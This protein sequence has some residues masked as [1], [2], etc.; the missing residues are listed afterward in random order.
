MLN[1][2]DTAKW[3]SLKPY[4]QNE[5]VTRGGFIW[6]SKGNG[7]QGHDPLT[8][9]S[10]TYW[11]KFSGSGGGS[12]G[13]NYILNPTA[14]S[15]DTSSWN[16]Y[17]DQVS[18][19]ISTSFTAATNLV[20]R[21][22]HGFVVGDAVVFISGTLGGSLVT[23]TKYYVVEVP[24]SGSFKLSLTR[25][26]AIFDITSDQGANTVVMHRINFVNGTSGTTSADLAFS[27]SSSTPERGTFS[28]LLSK[29]SVSGQAGKGVSTDFT[30]D[31]ADRGNM[32]QISFDLSL[33][34]SSTFSEGDIEIWIYDVTNASLIQPTPFKVAGMTTGATNHYRFVSFFQANSTSTSYRFG[35]HWMNPISTLYSVKMDS[36]LVA[37]QTQSVGLAAMDP[38]EYFPDLTSWTA[39]ALTNIS[40]GRLGKYMLIDGQ[41]ELTA[42]V[43][44]NIR[45]P[46]PV[47]HRID[48]DVSAGGTP[49]TGD[50][51]YGVIQGIDFS[52][53][54][55][56]NNASVVKYA[57]EEA[58][59]PIDNAGT[60]EWEAN[61][62][63][64]WASGD[65]INIS[66]R[67]PIVG[68]SSNVVMST[69]DDGREVYVDAV[70][71]DNS[72]GADSPI[73]FNDI[74]RDS[75]G[76]FNTSTG[77]YRVP[78]TGRYFISM[79]HD[80]TFGAVVIYL[81]VNG[82]T[83][84]GTNE[85]SY[86]STILPYSAISISLNAGDQIAVQSSNT[87]AGGAGNGRLS[88]TKIASGKQIAA[89]EKI[90]TQ[91]TRST[92]QTIADNFASLVSYDTVVKDSHGAW[93]NSTSEFVC[94]TAGDYRISGISG[95][96]VNATG[97]R[98]LNIYKNGVDS[99]NVYIMPGTGSVSLI[100][101]F[102]SIKLDCIAGDKFSL[103]VIQTSGGNLLHQSALVTFEKI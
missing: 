3:Q 81:S 92:S 10:S 48:T 1:V 41:I 30:I 99:G 47:G 36:F 39:G 91:V 69:E 40:W 84:N 95:W 5:F 90:I 32:L 75:H 73:L 94:P 14:E 23:N 13:T 15:G 102:T 24:S 46:I 49:A 59:A 33:A 76:A 2:I 88:I 82:T 77:I 50:G 55:R 93:N 37:P 26:G 58:L 18:T 9:T 53:S 42:A 83:Y 63:L 86:P 7:N 100:I 70:T 8:D 27:A 97:G 68:W 66:A 89:S 103:V 96:D 52:T 61:T 17:N 21:A 20:T 28:F 80:A 45:I 87:Y 62:P 54:T 44:G 64:T 57:A 56:Y 74:V 79:M 11:A 16:L 19:S 35:I 72:G 67:V 29:S 65:I 12:S 31:N 51:V 4:S 78:S 25:G 85:M 6:K 60:S 22:A 43:T 71:P 34:S 101:P 98:F 38:I